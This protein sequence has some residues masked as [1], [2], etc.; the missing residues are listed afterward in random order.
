MCEIFHEI[1]RNNDINLLL[2]PCIYT[3]NV[4]N[5]KR[6][7]IF[8][9][10]GRWKL[11]PI[12]NLL[13]H[14][15]FLIKIYLEKYN[16]YETILHWNGLYGKFWI[17]WTAINFKLT[18]WRKG[19]AKYPIDKKLR[20]THAGAWESYEWTKQERSPFFGPVGPACLRQD[21]TRPK[22]QLRL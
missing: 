4:W 6:L 18:G 21:K 13:K 2:E 9:R 7:Y 5:L 22:S 19:W 17:L 12:L 11:L 10:Y 3:R 1:N 15:N 8:Q 20:R 16:W 14:K